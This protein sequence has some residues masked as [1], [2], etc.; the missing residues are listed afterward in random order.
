MGV[1]ASAR[2]PPEPVGKASGL[3]RVFEASRA[4]FAIEDVIPVVGLDNFVQAVWSRVAPPRD[5][6]GLTTAVPH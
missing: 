1:F 2:F 5:L 3:T 6:F 4:Q